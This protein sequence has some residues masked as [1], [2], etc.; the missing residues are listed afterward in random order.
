MNFIIE[1][2]NL[3]KLCQTGVSRMLKLPERV[4]EVFLIRLEGIIAAYDFSDIENDIAFEVKRKR[5][6]NKIQ[7]RLLDNWRI[8]A[9]LIVSEDSKE[10]KYILI[11]DIIQINRK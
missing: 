7:L 6:Q 8:E 11:K 2:S 9:E 1:N 4:I 3:L 10:I 5:S